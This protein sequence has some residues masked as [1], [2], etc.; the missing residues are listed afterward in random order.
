MEKQAL[1]IPSPQE[2]GL[3]AKFSTWRPKQPEAILAMGLEGKRFKAISAPT[4][5]GKTISYVAASILSELPTCITTNSRGLQD[6]VMA[7]FK[8][9]GMVDIRGRRNYQ[10]NMKP[11]LTCEEGR[12]IRCPY[13][14]QVSCPCSQA[15]M[16]AAT[17]RLVITNYDKWTSARAYGQGMEHFQQLVLDEGHEAVEAVSRAMQVVLHHREIEEE[18]KLPFPCNKY[19]NNEEEMQ[20]WKDWAMGIRPVVL[21][22]LYKAREDLNGV[23]DPKPSLVKRMLHLQNLSRRLTTISTASTKS[24][25]VEQVEG[26]FQFDPIHPGRFAESTL[27]LGTPHI[28]IVSATL[29]LK[30]LYLL[31]LSQDSF[32]FHE[33]DSSFD[34]KRCPVYW[35][36]TMRVDRNADDLS[37]LWATLDRIIAKRRDRKGIIHTI[38]YARAQQVMQQSRFASS[39]IL[40][41]RGES[42]GPAVEQF[43][44]AGP[45]A[46]LV[47]PS[48]SAGYDFQGKDAEWQFICKLPFPD[49]RSKV[50]RARREADPEL[51]LFNTAQDFEQICGRPMR[52]ENDQAETFIGDNHLEWFWPKYKHF[53]TK[54]FRDRFRRVDTLP[55]PPEAL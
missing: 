38:S 6:Q 1:K 25:V 16:R 5:S 45:G 20:G 48:V 3:P 12:A 35:V 44:R 51:G 46:I 36:P 19:T 55:K 17:S 33:F 47:S 15:E 23:S 32:D 53:T 49:G 50:A 4:G 29:R 42:V 14:G 41:K 21:G 39:M 28:I 52:S 10:C 2:L 13:K 30:S 34:P 18:L 31:G 7:D 24:W 37:L 26:G 43:K 27:F 40:N 9:I 54:S 22:E 8:S 11:D